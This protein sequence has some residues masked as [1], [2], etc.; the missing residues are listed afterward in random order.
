MKPFCTWTA[1]LLCVAGAAPARAHRLEPM[2]TNFARPFE[3]GV[4][5][6]QFTYAWD[7]RL[8]E[9]VRT[10]LIPELE[11]E[12]GVSH[13]AQFSVAMPVILEKRQGE[14][15][16]AGAGHIEMS[17][18]YLLAGGG[19]KSWALSIN[20]SV[21]PPTGD[22]SLAGDTTEAGAALHFDYNIGRR[23]FFHGNYGW[24]ATLGGS[25]PRE[26]TFVYKS[27]LI[28]PASYRWNPGV[29][30]LG[31][32]DT[33]TGRTELVVQPEVIYYV[34]PR[35]ELKFGLPV[36]FT[37]ASPGLGVRA[38]VVWIFGRARDH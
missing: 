17:F 1:L 30:V 33:A 29:E 8:R 26:H 6:L 16:A 34:S 37:A 36:G 20:P 3:P 32:T 22:R 38:Q 13:R 9:G 11:F 19:G 35:W 31:R 15:A 12:L 14:P 5:N 25:E 28:V 2:E 23:A 18:R 24:F 10:H 27:A 4:G 21:T 7:R